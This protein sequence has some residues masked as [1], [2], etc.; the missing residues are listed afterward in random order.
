[1]QKRNSN[2][3]VESLHCQEILHR[4][5]G[6]SPRPPTLNTESL[7]LTHGHPHWETSLLN[8]L[9]ARC[10]RSVHFLLLWRAV[11]SQV[12]PSAALQH[13]V[14]AST[15]H[16]QPP[17]CRTP[18]LCPSLTAPGPL[19]SPLQSTKLLCS[20]S[21][22]GCPGSRSAPFEEPFGPLRLGR[23]QRS[24]TPCPSPQLRGRSQGSLPQLP[25]SYTAPPPL[26]TKMAPPPLKPHTAPL[27][28]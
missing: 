22:R 12:P 27:R 5:L 1:M 10:H 28:H 17:H 23:A 20:R 16:R 4:M 21:P 14:E 8:S 11:L 2:T 13:P 24:P 3:A 19:C 26:R 25:P 7:T 18:S 9:C 15:N 6:L